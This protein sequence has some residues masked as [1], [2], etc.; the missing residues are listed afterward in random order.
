MKSLF[1]KI[2]N[3][4]HNFVNRINGREAR[5]L[6]SELNSLTAELE[7][8]T[9]EL[10]TKTAELET[11]T[12]E[13]HLRENRLHPFVKEALS[14]LAKGWT[15]EDG[16]YASGEK[17]IFLGLFEK[18]GSDKET[19]HNYSQVYS[20]LLK[21]KTDP[22]ILE[23]GLGSLNDYAYAGLPPGGS[24]KAWRE[25]L[26]KALIIGADI[27]PESILAIAEPGFI[28]DQTSSDSLAGFV[29][30]IG[31]FA[32]FDLIVDDGFHD[33]HANLRTLLSVFPLLSQDGSYVIEDVHESLIDLWVVMARSIDADFA[34]VDLRK[35]RPEVNDNI[36]LIFTKR[37]S[38]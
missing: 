17:N 8:K 21:N 18:F 19:R 4:L 13:A 16:K 15:S 12:A 28:V 33:P 25:G 30:N 11:K 34:I 36:L 26:P 23:I 38:G 5:T 9:A 37:D 27:D 6:S 32:P 14:L 35:D 20:K 24:I 22:H 1:W 3:R 29:T 31:Q 10:E 7:T 2:F